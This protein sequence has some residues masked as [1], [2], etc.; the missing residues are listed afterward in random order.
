[1]GLVIIMTAHSL[2]YLVH[3]DVAIIIAANSICPDIDPS[4][5]NETKDQLSTTP[6]NEV[7]PMLERRAR[8]HLSLSRGASQLRLVVQTAEEDRQSPYGREMALARASDICLRLHS[9]T[10]TCA[11]APC[12][13]G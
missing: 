13:V 10:G 5:S 12:P 4:H 9:S 6:W 3:G 11:R 1:M 2:A 8:L 7:K